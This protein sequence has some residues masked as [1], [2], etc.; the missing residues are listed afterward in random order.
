[1][2]NLEEIIANSKDTREVKRA[3]AVKMLIQGFSVS[4]VEGVLQVSDS[5]I[6]KWK[7][8]YEAE[9]AEALLLKYKGKKSYLDDDSK[10][11]VISFL[12]KKKTFSVED[13]RDY[14]EDK[15]QVIYK[16]KQSYYERL[17]EGG[18][19][20]KRSEK[21][22]PKRNESVVEQKRQEIQN[23]FSVLSEEIKSGELAVLIADECHLLWGDTTGYVWGKRNEKVEVPIVNQ[24]SRQTYYGAVDYLTGEFFLKAYPQGN[25]IY[26][27]SFLKELLEHRKETKLI[28][29]WD[30][31]TYHKGEEMQKYLEEVNGTL[32]EKDWRISCVLLAPHAPDQNPVEDIW[33]L[34]K[35]FLRRHF[36][37]NKTFAQVK[38]S[39]FNF[40]NGQV[41][42]FPKLSLFAS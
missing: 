15:Y 6:S 1:M 30:G 8:I 14:L 5:F 11:K 10:K 16:S 31:A 17:K 12:K 26:T 39:F 23:I 40:L 24:K 9:G 32:D 2:L 29:I 20:W 37:E 41:F 7:L 3:L 19:S 33:F 38:D 35:T 25:G 18:L 28:L 21:V 4:Q 27:V 42:D 34:V 22:N 36:F 13:L